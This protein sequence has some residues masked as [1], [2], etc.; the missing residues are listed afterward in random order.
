MIRKFV[1]EEAAYLEW[2]AANATGF[3]VNTDDPL[4]QDSYPMVHKAQHKVISSPART[5]YTTDRYIKICGLNLDELERFVVE[6]YGR[7]LNRCKQCM[8]N[9]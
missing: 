9:P 5:N 2:I 1:N 7:Q 8:R 3:V 4:T 6:Q